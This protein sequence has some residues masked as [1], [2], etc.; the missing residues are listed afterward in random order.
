MYRPEIEWFNDT[1]PIKQ[2]S[3][4]WIRTA[5][6]ALGMSV[7][8]LAQRLGKTPPT[9]NGYEEREIDGRITLN[10]LR[11]VADALNCDLHYT[12]VPRQPIYDLRKAQAEKKAARLMASVNTQMNLEKQPL[13][14]AAQRMTTDELTHQLL[15]SNKL[16]DKD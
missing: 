8:A 6:K 14:T 11:E 2:P 7:K 4:G 1:K 13:S 16:W 3:G 9:V 10:T 15:S 12:L 5:R